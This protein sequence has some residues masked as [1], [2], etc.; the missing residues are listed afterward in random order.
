MTQATHEPDRPATPDERNKTE[1]IHCPKCDQAYY[2]CTVNEETA[3]TSC[4]ATIRDDET[5]EIV[6][7]AIRDVVLNEDQQRWLVLPRNHHIDLVP[8]QEALH[9]WQLWLCDAAAR[10]A[11]TV[12]REEQS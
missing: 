12:I 5:F 3:C 2:A 1:M 6:R 11:I 9:D 4:D 8:N 10:A 7:N